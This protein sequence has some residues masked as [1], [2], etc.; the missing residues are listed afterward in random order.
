MRI[1][2]VGHHGTVG[3][4]ESTRPRSSTRRG[5]RSTIGGGRVSIGSGD[6]IRGRGGGLGL[7]LGVGVAAETGTL[8]QVLLL[9]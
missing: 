8:E 9:A 6:A 4:R 2:T 3:S 1:D 7:G 5:G